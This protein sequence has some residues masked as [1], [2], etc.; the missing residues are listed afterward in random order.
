MNADRE[1]NGRYQTMTSHGPDYWTIE[2]AIPWA[3]L[4][5]AGVP[6]KELGINFRR[7]Q[8]RL[9]SSADWQAPID[10]DPRTYGLLIME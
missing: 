2:A 10:Y 5:V 6:G 4:G 8:F 1:W 9:G 3:E 7:K